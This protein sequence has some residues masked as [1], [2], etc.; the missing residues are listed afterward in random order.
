M[1]VNAITLTL[2]LVS[3]GPVCLIER[4]LTGPPRVPENPRML[5][6]RTS[7]TFPRNSL[8]ARWFSWLQ[9]CN[10]NFPYQGFPPR[11]DGSLNI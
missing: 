5:F 4:V 6:A 1:T 2:G 10:R 8:L 3:L 9:L 11:Q 7:N